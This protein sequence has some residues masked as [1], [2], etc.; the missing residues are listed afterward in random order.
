MVRLQRRGIVSPSL[1]AD[2]DWLEIIEAYLCYTFNEPDILEVA[3]ED[4]K[5]GVTCVGKSMRR[6]PD[7]NEGLSIELSV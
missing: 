7:G 2:D 1:P 4:L 6:C 5:S 3:L